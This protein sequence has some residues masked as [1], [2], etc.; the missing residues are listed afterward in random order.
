MTYATYE[1][2]LLEH[3]ILKCHSHNYDYYTKFTNYR[4]LTDLLY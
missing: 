2:K 1:D 4:A 3:Q